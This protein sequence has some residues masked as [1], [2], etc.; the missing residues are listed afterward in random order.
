MKGMLLAILSAGMCSGL[1]AQLKT[2]IDKKDVKTFD[3]A[4]RRTITE[5]YACHQ[6]AEKPYLRLHIPEAPATR[7]IDLRPNAD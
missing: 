7:M 4:Y 1:L 2:A 3:A 6:L 5:C